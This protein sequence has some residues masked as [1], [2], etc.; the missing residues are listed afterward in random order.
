MSNLFK[1]NNNL[2]NEEFKFFE[3]FNQKKIGIDD[4]INYIKQNLHVINNPHTIN[5]TV[6]VIEEENVSL[7]HLQQNTV[8]QLSKLPNN[9]SNIFKNFIGD[10][11]RIGVMRFNLTGR[12][13]EGTG[14][15]NNVSLLSSILSC[16]KDDFILQPCQTQQVYI[17][18]LNNNLIG[19]INSEK[20][21][22]LGFN[23][24]DF[25]QISIISQ[26]KSYQNTKIILRLIAEY[27]NIN[28]FLLNITTDEL[29]IANDFCKYKKNILIM[30]LNDESFEPIFFKNNKVLTFDS[31]LIKH[32]IS[33]NCF[34]NLIDIPKFEEKIVQNT[35]TKNVTYTLREK[36]LLRLLNEQN[37]K[38]TKTPDYAVENDV[39]GVNEI[40]ES[41][42]ACD[43]IESNLSDSE[44]DT[45]PNT[46]LIN[47]IKK[48]VYDEKSCKLDELQNDAKLLG[49]DITITKSGPTGIA[50]KKNKTKKELCDDINKYLN[51]E[52]LNKV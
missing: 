30:L 11:C 25:K 23:K 36:R 43:N 52:I 22:D 5:E 9:L 35:N 3:N 38:E 49:I 31:N 47:K 15:K 50:K 17:S 33:T 28:I 32:L 20:Y 10:M 29:S 48:K 40:T 34:N 21:N 45:E 14:C 8:K 44:N 19:F 46:D 42:E 7:T 16:L 39:E 27:F 26:L 24:T 51:N 18:Q 2:A 1:K 37:L 12:S 4:L 41:S 6:D 13:N